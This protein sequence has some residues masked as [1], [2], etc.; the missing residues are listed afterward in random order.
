MFS[1]N[2]NNVKRSDSPMSTTGVNSIVFGTEI[3][4]EV[5]SPGN[6]RVDGKVEGNLIIEG[7][8]IIGD[9]GVINGD[10]KCKSAEIEGIFKGNLKVEEILSLKSSAQIY[11]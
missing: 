1:N 11:G 3:Q 9:K 2:K 10:V 6:F 5:K 4:G 8:L 7:R